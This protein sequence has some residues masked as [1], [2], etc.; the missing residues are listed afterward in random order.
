MN[1]I[2]INGKKVLD[3]SR[4][5]KYAAALSLAYDAMFE[6]NLTKGLY[7]TV[8][9][10]KDKV[11]V[12][13]KGLLEELCQS[14]GDYIHP[15][16]RAGFLSVFNR[17]SLERIFEKQKQQ[18]FEYQK[19]LDSGR[20]AWTRAILLPYWDDGDELLL[21]YITDIEKEKNREM[22]EKARVDLAKVFSSI[23]LCIAEVNL[24]D[25]DVFIIHCT[26]DPETVGNNYEWD[27]LLEL[28]IANHI[29]PEDSAMVRRSFCFRRLRTLW[30]GWQKNQ[31]MDCRYSR[32]AGYYEWV[33]I[34][35]IYPSQSDFKAYLAVRGASEHHLLK[36]I[37]D[38]YVYKN[39]DYFMYL[40]AKNNYYTMFSGSE[41]GVPI[42]PSESGDYGAEIRRHAECYVVPEDR[43]MVIRE[44]GIERVLQALDEKGEHS[45]F[46]GIMDPVRG[47]TRKQLQFMYYD[48]MNKKV[49]LARTDVTKVYYEQKLQQE[50]LRIALER[51]QKDL[52]TGL[53]NQQA[54][55]DFI[56]ERILQLEEKPAALLVIDM[57]NFKMVN[58]TLGHLKGNDLLCCVASA[59][60]GQLGDMEL[61][62]R[63]GGDEFIAFLTGFSTVDE[64]K[65]RVNQ[66][67]RAIEERID[68]PYGSLKFSCSIGVALYPKQGR[69]Y[70]ELFKQADEA[71]YRAKRHG[72]NG[73]SF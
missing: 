20:Y 60:K 49:L 39:C 54:A 50:K 2:S 26:D 7:H 15:D 45:F 23:Y 33:E 37:V 48:R 18:S 13:E 11:I 41:N 73:F 72:K 14:M 65:H 68:E 55:G 25:G 28:F 56:S 52:L 31:S 22:S 66:L 69:E 34:G 38:R 16:S 27:S 44:M 36:S 59:I 35:I 8:F 63:I 6:M 32:N 3:D 12:K 70:C 53:Y 57:D 10:A 30:E 58:D 4:M 47:Y 71:L 24:M 62:G 42:P 9:H 40:D 19:R 43:E 29:H 64:L 1:K 67:C 46:C 21:C 5:E 17:N 61:A 51:A